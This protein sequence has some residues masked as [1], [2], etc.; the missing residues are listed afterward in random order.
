MRAL[1][2]IE[3]KNIDIAQTFLTGYKLQT[4][5]KAKLLCTKVCIVCM[6]FKIK[7]CQKKRR[8]K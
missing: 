3:G 2:K 6:F 5:L 4:K 8:K 1:D 7:L